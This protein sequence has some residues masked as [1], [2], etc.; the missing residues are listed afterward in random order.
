MDNYESDDGDQQIVVDTHTFDCADFFCAQ[1]V[2]NFPDVTTQVTFPLA[3]RPSWIITV[4]PQAETKPID[5]FCHGIQEKI[6]WEQS[7]LVGYTIVREE[8][9]VES[10]ADFS[11]L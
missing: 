8:G 11:G 7:V 9:S 10:A 1:V 4:G 6:F 5:D 3:W 2:R